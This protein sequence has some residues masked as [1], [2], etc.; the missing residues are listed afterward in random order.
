MNS[1]Y[2][3]TIEWLLVTALALI[4][5][6]GIAYLAYT[7][8]SVLGNFIPPDLIEPVVGTST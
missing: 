1:K 3:T 5:I 4:V 2:V 7:L 8:G 6:L